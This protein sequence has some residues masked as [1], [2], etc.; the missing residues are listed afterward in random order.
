MSG[1]TSWVGS[2]LVSGPVN[3]GGAG[4]LGVGSWLVVLFGC[5][6]VRK[7]CLNSCCVGMPGVNL[8][9]VSSFLMVGGG[10]GVEALLLGGWFCSSSSL[11]DLVLVALA[12]LPLLFCPL[13]AIPAL[14]LGFFSMEGAAFLVTDDGRSNPSLGLVLAPMIFCKDGSSGM[15]GTGALALL[16]DGISLRS[17]FRGHCIPSSCF[18]MSCCSSMLLSSLL[19]FHCSVGCA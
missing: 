7:S 18:S 1:S 14:G 9:K 6:S 12:L 5:S 2:L 17:L 15:G 8:G 10:L 11:P 16:A 4:E 19:G 3:I 13:S